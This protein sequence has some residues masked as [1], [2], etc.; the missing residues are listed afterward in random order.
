MA[1][2]ALKISG[3]TR[4]HGRIT[5]LDSLSLDIA[6]GQFVGLL[7]PAGSG[8]STLLRILAGFDRA[9]SGSVDVD[10]ARFNR[11]PPHRRGFGVV[12]QADQLFPHLTIAENVALPLRLRGVPRRAR[13]A[14]A[15]ETLELFQLG[16]AG[17]LLPQ[18]ATNAQRQRAIVARATVFGPAVLL[19]DDPFR[20][21]DAQGRATLIASLRRAHDMLGATTL[22]ASRAPADT[23]PVCDR[24]AVLRD[25]K[26]VQIDSPER[27]FDRPRDAS[28]AAAL[29]ATNLLPGT[30][31]TVEEDFAMVQLACG[32][33]VEGACSGALTPG[34]A[35]LLHLRPDRIAIAAT[36]AA[37]FGGGAIDATL[38]QARFL[39]E[40]YELHLLIGS[41]AELV[42][43]RPAA[44][45]L[46]GL[47]PGSHAAIAWQ[48]QHALVFGTAG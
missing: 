11:R 23:L 38:L 7:G 2:A 42:V 17:D 41:G 26:V 6:P 8:K 16:D 46:R 31:Q 34:E 4:M 44:I 45:G 39:G 40:T 9:A 19:L 25:G 12:Q 37:D 5:A 43:Q 15:R 1:A 21:Q 24:I 14:L 22:L 36:S 3:L 27:L 13:A 10:G 33:V 32:P 48:P 28:V 47:S 29:G 20:D 30:V 35:C 18:A